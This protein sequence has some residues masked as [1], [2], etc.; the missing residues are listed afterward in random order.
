MK[1]VIP[2]AKR[3]AHRLLNTEISM[4]VGVAVSTLNKG[5][6]FV[7]QGAP[8]M[9]VEHDTISAG[10]VH[11]VN[12]V[13]GSCWAIPGTEEVWPAFDTTLTYKTARR[14]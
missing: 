14:G 3:L 12:L 13:T 10:G 1:K 9:Y 6:V 11:I 7:R 2:E 4:V 5:D 8:C